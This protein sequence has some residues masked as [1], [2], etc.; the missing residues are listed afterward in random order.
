ME[1]DGDP[2]NQTSDHIGN[3]TTC[4]VDKCNKLHSRFEKVYSLIRDQSCQLSIQRVLIY[5]CWSSLGSL[6][7]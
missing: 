4:V 3:I 1:Q 6:G 5:L 7:F 2:Q